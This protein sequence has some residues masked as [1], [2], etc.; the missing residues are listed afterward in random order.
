ML[1]INYF[2]LIRRL[3]LVDGL[4]QRETAKRL[5]LS[6][7]SVKKAILN[8]EPAE[9]T[10]RQPKKRMVKFSNVMIRAASCGMVILAEERRY[11]NRNPRPL[12]GVSYTQF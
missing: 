4:S 11:V 6:H 12:R 9:Y 7:D 8:S 3:V 5:G 10:L 1:K 2:D